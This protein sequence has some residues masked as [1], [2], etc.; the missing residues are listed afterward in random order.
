MVQERTCTRC[1][2]SQLLSSHRPAKNRNAAHAVHNPPTFSTHSEKHFH[3]HYTHHRERFHN[4]HAHTTFSPSLAPTPDRR[5]TFESCHRGR[6][7]NTRSATNTTR[8]T[9]HVSMHCTVVN[10][11]SH[12]HPSTST[13][14]THSMVRVNPLHQC[15]SQ[16]QQHTYNN[17][18]LHPTMKP[19]S[20]LTLRLVQMW[21]M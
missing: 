9:N 15:C 4:L 21:W 14:I 11:T 2:R 7:A 3:T 1:Y 17:N 19:S 8:L 10:T 6:E 12:T 16:R 18:K 5:A 13:L 20:D